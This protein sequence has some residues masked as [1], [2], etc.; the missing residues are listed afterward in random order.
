MRLSACGDVK[1]IGRA[2]SPVDK[3]NGRRVAPP[4]AG[5]REGKAVSRPK[6][7]AGGSPRRPGVSGRK[8]EG[9]EAVLHF[10]AVGP[11]LDQAPRDRGGGLARIGLAID[12][13]ARVRIAED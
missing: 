8:P 9:L 10:H 13:E 5:L 1:F 12:H 7:M 2:N 4:A 11:R 6:R 3:K